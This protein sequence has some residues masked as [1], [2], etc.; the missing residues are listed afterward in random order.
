MIVYRLKYSNKFTGPIRWFIRKRVNG[1]RYLAFIIVSRWSTPNDATERDIAMRNLRL[2]N[3]FLL[4]KT[5]VPAM[6][7][8]ALLSNKLFMRHSEAIVINE[9]LL[10]GGIFDIEICGKL[11]KLTT[12]GALIDAMMEPIEKG[13]VLPQ[14][15]FDIEQL[16]VAFKEISNSEH[17][18]HAP[19]IAPF[20]A[21][22]VS[23]SFNDNVICPYNMKNII[24]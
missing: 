3:K 2:G 7:M 1:L 23:N 18:K 22:Y 9:A 15:M 17:D 12:Y 21:R 11:H 13:L 4:D 10:Y 16:Y 24:K 6:A 8:I 19:C 14:H 5:S 20:V